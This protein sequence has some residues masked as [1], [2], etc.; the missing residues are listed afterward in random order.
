[1]CSTEQ[2]KRL[3]V[4]ASGLDIQGTNP[5]PQ[6][7]GGVKPRQ[8]S[9]TPSAERLQVSNLTVYTSGRGGSGSTSSGGNGGVASVGETGKQQSLD[10][11]ISDERA[12]LDQVWY[13]HKYFIK[14]ELEVK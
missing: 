13:P 4:L 1:M 6:D 10:S 7:G 2:I 8:R 12:P 14:D 3:P 5:S 9:I 11:A